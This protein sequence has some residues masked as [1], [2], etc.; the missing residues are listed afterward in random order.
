MSVL[1][2]SS[3]WVGHFKQR[4]EHLVVLLLNGMVVCH[5]YVV[6]EVACGTPPSRQA[7]IGMLGELES[8]PVAT[9]TELL[10]MLNARQL[11]GRGRGCGLVDISLLASALL[12]GN[13]RIWTLDKRLG[14]MAGEFDKS[15]RPVL[16]S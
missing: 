8:T 13:V 15:Y 11:Y 1:V 12:L 9:Q 4:N 2:D 5:P 16:H 10:A 14:S 6:A 7:I 3:V